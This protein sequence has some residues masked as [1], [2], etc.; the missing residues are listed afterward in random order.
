MARHMEMSDNALPGRGGLDVTFA[1]NSLDEAVAE[2]Q[3]TITSRIFQVGAIPKGVSLI[4]T[5]VALAFVRGDQAAP[6]DT[7]AKQVVASYA[8]WNQIS[9]EYLDIVF[10]GWYNDG[11]QVGFNGNKYFI[12]CYEEIQKISKWHYSG[13]TDIL[14]LDFEIPVNSDGSVRPG[15]FSFE[16][17]IPWRVTEIIQE[18]K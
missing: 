5:P 14:L 16:R 11:G 7:L 18:K 1:V 6:A 8:Y 3:R 2:L 12:Q 4:R 17:C 13:E 15:M 10:F 9:A